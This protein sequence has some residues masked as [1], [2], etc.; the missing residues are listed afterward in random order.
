VRDLMVWPQKLCGHRQSEQLGITDMEG[1]WRKFTHI[2]SDV[3][4]H[5]PIGGNMDCHLPAK[6]S[7]V[8]HWDWDV[9]LFIFQLP[10]TD[11]ISNGFPDPS[12]GKQLF[13]SFCIYI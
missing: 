13:I 9:F 11:S 4:T 8:I 1:T 12:K 2:C 7:Q 10:S 6:V 3:D 5:V